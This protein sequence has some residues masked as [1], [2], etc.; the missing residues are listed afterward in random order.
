[1]QNNKPCNL[2]VTSKKSEHQITPEDSEKIIN[3][4]SK[5]FKESDIIDEIKKHNYFESKSV[6]NHRKKRLKKHLQ[7][8]N[9]KIILGKLKPRNKKLKQEIL[10][11]YRNGE[12][13]LRRR[14]KK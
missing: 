3:S 6:K 10:E 4:F 5:K 7:S 14:G 1:M 8:I 9:E 13:S 11:K 2:Y 12:I